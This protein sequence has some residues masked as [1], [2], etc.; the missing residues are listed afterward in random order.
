MEKL[1][2][3]VAYYRV[4]TQRQGASGLGLDSQRSAVL[5]FIKS[6]GNRIIKEFTEIESGKNNKRPELLKAIEFAQQNDCTLIVA[7]LDRLS[8]DMNF[9]TA[10]MASKVKFIAADMPEANSLTLHIIAALAEYERKM[11]SE[12]TRSA[13]QAKKQREPEWVPPTILPKRAD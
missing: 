8:R 3:Y 11:I 6:N 10:L 1:K 13:L 2:A 9:I 7:K 12:R 4:S 5:Q